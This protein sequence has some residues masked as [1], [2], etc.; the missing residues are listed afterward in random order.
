MQ[1]LNFHKLYDLKRLMFINKLSHLHHEITTGLM[2]W[3]LT[4]TDINELH[5]MYDIT[6]TSRSSEIFKKC[7]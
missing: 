1:R 6:M 7:V 3:Y 4:L 2:P 5:F